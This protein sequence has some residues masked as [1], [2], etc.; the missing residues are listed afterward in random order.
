MV[1]ELPEGWRLPSILTAISQLAQFV[2]FFFLF[3]RLYFPKKFTYV[4]AIYFIFAIG[5][6]S[7]VCLSLL[8]N[9]TIAIGHEKRSLYLYIFNFSL[10][11][12]GNIRKL[13]YNF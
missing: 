5:A 4:R 13:K 3:G 8:W 7:C 1:D 11:F 9:K 2:P 6:V 12:L 10:S